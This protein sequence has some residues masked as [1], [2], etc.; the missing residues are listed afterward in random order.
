MKLV[1]ALLALFMLPAMASQHSHD[2]NHKLCEG[3]VPENDLKIPVNHFWSNKQAGITEAQFNGVIDKFIELYEDE[4]KAKGGV[5]KVNRLWTDPTVNASAEQ[6]GNTW[7]INMYGGLARHETITRDAF[8][9]VICHEGGH[10]LGGAPRYAGWFGEEWASNE[11]QSDYFAN[12]KCLRRFF[13]DEMIGYRAVRTEANAAYVDACR[14]THK[15][16]I[17]SRICIRSAL[18]GMQVAKLFQALRKET[19]APDFGTPDKK[20]VT[21]TYDSHPA[22]QCRLDT[23]LAGSVCGAKV[24]DAVS[25]TDW[26]AG[27]CVSNV[28]ARPSCWFKA[29]AAASET[30]RLEWSGRTSPSEEAH[31]TYY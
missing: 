24:S 31:K 25:N 8:A 15:N 22:T 28:G 10:H 5:L 30:E 1:A 18:A 14:A 11:G 29:P 13:K 16:S 2:H 17:D 26:K 4:I 20:V 3:F 23:Y 12:L 19:V 27:T 6:T 9:L 7:T 21:K